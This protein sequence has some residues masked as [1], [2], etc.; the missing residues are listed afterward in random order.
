MLRVTY[1]VAPGPTGDDTAAVTFRLEMRSTKKALDWVDVAVVGDGAAVAPS[2][3]PAGAGGAGSLRLASGLKPRDKAAEKAAKPKKA[4]LPLV[5]S[6]PGAAL[7]GVSVAVRVSYKVAESDKVVT[8]DATLV[9]RAASLLRATAIEPDA[10]RT[11]MTSEGSQFTGAA[12]VVPLWPGAA[13]PEATLKAVL[14]VMRCFAVVRS[15]KHAVLYSRAAAGSGAGAAVTATAILKP[16]DKVLQ[17]QI[18]A[19][20][21]LAE[22]L[23]AEVTAAVAAAGAAAAAADK[24]KD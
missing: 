24:E 20:G 17:L 7:T 16:E 14:A 15:P 19:V 18:K 23:L 9:L 3:L 5:L 13:G 22:V 4:T 12:G 6:T 8:L 10:F 11:L 21:A 1:A 2:D